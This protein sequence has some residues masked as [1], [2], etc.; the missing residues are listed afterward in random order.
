[1]KP[2]LSL[3]LAR[4]PPSPLARITRRIALH[5]AV[6]VA[7]ALVALGEER[8]GRDVVLVDVRF[9]LR[10]GPA[11]E[12]VQFEHAGRGEFEGREG[13]A[14][15]ALRGASA[16]YECLDAQF[17]VCSLGGFDLV[18]EGKEDVG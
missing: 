7:H 15:A 18:E 13:R 10:E 6:P 5:R 8:V 14:C 2:T 11:E 9:D 16:G 17:A 1:M 4:P 12:G 3:R